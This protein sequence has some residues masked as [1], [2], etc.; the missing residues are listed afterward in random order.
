MRFLIFFGQADE[1]VFGL[2]NAA[3]RLENPPVNLITSWTRSL[4]QVAERLHNHCAILRAA[5]ARNP[6]LHPPLH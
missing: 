6:R 1:E 3:E 4:A 2:V 5:A